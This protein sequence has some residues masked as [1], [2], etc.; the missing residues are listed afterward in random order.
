M[1]YS[2]D[3]TR[4]SSQAV[5]AGCAR[6]SRGGSASGPNSQRRVISRAKAAFVVSIAGLLVF[7]I[8]Q[9]WLDSIQVSYEFPLS[10]PAWLVFFPQAMITTGLA[11]LAASTVL[12]LSGLLPWKR[13]VSKY[14][15]LALCA[16]LLALLLR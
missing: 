4:E 3:A 6:D 8:G 5:V 11:A 2:I 14:A 10:P 12:A 15:A 1:G 9:H 7:G 16:D 13:G